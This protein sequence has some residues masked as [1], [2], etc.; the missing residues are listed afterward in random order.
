MDCPDCEGGRP[1]DINANFF[2][3]TVY[4]IPIVPNMDNWIR[5]YRLI[6]SSRQSTWRDGIRLSCNPY[7]RSN[8]PSILISS[9]TNNLNRVKVSAR[10]WGVMTLSAE[11]NS[12]LKYFWLSEEIQSSGSIGRIT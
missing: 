4:V 8:S 2:I 11:L 5:E 9:L 6:L 10:I 7:Q 1:N 3:Y 12:L